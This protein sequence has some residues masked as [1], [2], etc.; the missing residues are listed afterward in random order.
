MRD[1]LW[2]RILFLVTLLNHFM[3][4]QHFFKDLKVIELANI[5]AGPAVGMFFAE[6]GA[7][8]IKLEHFRSGG[9]V[10]RGWKLPTE[11]PESEVSAYFS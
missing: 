4:L 8:V 1:H 9:D 11:D 10:T 6:L 2:L 3:E 5:L 7:R